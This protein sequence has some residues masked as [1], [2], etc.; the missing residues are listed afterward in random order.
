[1]G[2]PAN[3]T[4]YV[5]LG[6]GSSGPVSGATVTAVV[7]VAAF[8]QFTPEQ[9]EVFTDLRNHEAIHRA[10][11]RAAPGNQAIETLELNRSAVS[12]AV[13]NTTALLRN[14]EAFEDLGVSAYN[15]AGKYL[16]DAGVD[17]SPLL[18]WYV[19]IF[20]RPLQ[21]TAKTTSHADLHPRSQ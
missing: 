5:W 11:L 13:A 16:E 9:Q 15:G 20:R 2:A 10:S 6:F 4:R 19:V 3:D 14:A 21:A 17:R 8:R 1:M 18:V 7:A 12:S